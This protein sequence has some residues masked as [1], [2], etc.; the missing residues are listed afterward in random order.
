VHEYLKEYIDKKN[1]KNSYIKLIRDNY[2]HMTIG[3][4]R[5]IYFYRY[6]RSISVCPLLLTHSDDIDALENCYNN[7]LIKN[8]K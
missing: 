6:G 8:S 3:N 4:D 7:I 5:A 1:M 2:H